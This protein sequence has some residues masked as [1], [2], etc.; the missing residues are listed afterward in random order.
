MLNNLSS[1]IEAILGEK[2]ISKAKEQSNRYKQELKSSIKSYVLKSLNASLTVPQNLVLNKIAVN[3]EGDNPATIRKEIIKMIE[4]AMNHK[5]KV[6]IGY[7][8]FSKKIEQFI[9]PKYLYDN[10]VLYFYNKEAKEEE[11]IVLTKIIFTAL[12]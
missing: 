4:F 7:Y 2:I 5:S 8:I 9:V 11:S 10:R 3:Y 12:L 1:R 6:L